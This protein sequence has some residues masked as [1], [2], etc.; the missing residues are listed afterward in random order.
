MPGLVPLLVVAFIGALF[1]GRYFM[2][3]RRHSVL[4][5]WVQRELDFRGRQAA[6]A[7]AKAEALRAIDDVADAV[8]RQ[9]RSRS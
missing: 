2:A 1:V 4:E 9:L 6:I 3:W 7:L 8:L 5:Q